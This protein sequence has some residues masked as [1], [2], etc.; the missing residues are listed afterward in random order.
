MCGFHRGASQ[1]QMLQLSQK[2]QSKTFEKLKLSHKTQ[3]T[4]SQQGL[5]PWDALGLESLS[6]LSFLSFLR[7]FQHLAPF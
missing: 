7:Q 6:G 2:T 3:K 1:A 4:Q 5:G